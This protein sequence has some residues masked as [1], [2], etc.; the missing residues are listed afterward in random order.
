MTTVKQM[1][2][3]RRLHIVVGNAGQFQLGMKRRIETAV[4]AI[5]ITRAQHLV[6]DYERTIWNTTGKPPKN[7]VVSRR[8][9]TSPRYLAP[10]YAGEK[11]AA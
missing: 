5:P 3:N 2:P 6:D 10:A 1:N 11:M 8:L 9:S 7:R 4:G